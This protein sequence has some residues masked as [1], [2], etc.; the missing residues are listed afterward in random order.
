MP[1]F[2]YI[3]PTYPQAKRVIWD[4]LKQY[5]SN[6]PCE[7]NEADLRIDFP[8][9]KARIMLLSAENPVSLKGIYLDGVILDEAAEMHPDLWGEVIRPT[10]SDRRGWANFIG[11]PRGQNNFYDLYM[12]AKES[13][14]PDWFSAM[15][16]ASETGLVSQEE[17]ASN[18]KQ[19]TDDKFEQEFECSFNAGLIGSYFAKELSKAESEKRITRIPH[20]P[21]LP[22]DL[23]L[24]LGIND[25]AAV[26]FVQS[27]RGRH[28]L[29]DYYEVSGLSIPE[30]TAE[31]KKRNYNFGEWVFPHDAQ[32]RDFSTG[33][34]QLQ[35]FY[36]LG[37]RPQRVIPRIG[38]KQES[39]NA[40]RMIFG[41]C[42]F[43]AEKCKVG[44]KA[45]A[46]YQKKWDAKNN[47]FSESPLHNFASNGAD[48][49]QQ[50]ALG[51]RS[52]S[53]GLGP[54]ARR[55]IKCEMDYNPYSYTE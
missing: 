41:A 45:L 48:A 22:V 37:C 55:D 2:A 6:I 46:S 23:Y 33:K 24:D 54:N 8:H 14:D 12:Y 1:R 47:V 49:F 25:L 21:G 43:D 27:L 5:V 19:M 51:C 40:A 29:I 7:I 30:F 36:N 38:T 10:L 50:F 13:G 17:L 15:Y 20:D 3:A 44:L 9:N 31:I 16:K 52:D 39:I 4:P 11:T 32:A 34:T 28:R 18:R 53:R 26:W 35:V 42:E